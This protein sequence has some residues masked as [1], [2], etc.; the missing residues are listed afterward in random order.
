MR[1]LLMLAA[2]C[3]VIPLATPAQAE[4]QAW[5]MCMERNP[6]VVVYPPNAPGATLAAMQRTVCFWANVPCEV[7]LGTDCIP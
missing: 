3:L 1:S 4:E 5:P 6:D 7:A 2:A